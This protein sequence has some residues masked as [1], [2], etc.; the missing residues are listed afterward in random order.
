MYFL[1]NQK[2]DLFKENVFDQFFKLPVLSNEEFLMRTDIKKEQDKYILEIEVPGFNK[3]D[4]KISLNDGYLVVEA[5]REKTENVEDKESNYI[6]RERYYGKTSRSFYVGKIKENDIEA[7]FEN[8]ILTL[9]V[10]D[11]ETIKNANKK[12]IE[13]D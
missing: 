2:N 9:K 3:E 8:G 12:Y 1:K 5:S 13:I 10:L 11:Y 4:I 7:S 6:K